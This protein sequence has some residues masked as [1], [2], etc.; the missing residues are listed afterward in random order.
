MI[1]L[2]GDL[3]PIKGKYYDLIQKDWITG[4]VT[5]INEVLFMFMNEITLNLCSTPFLQIEIEKGEIWLCITND[6]DISNLNTLLNNPLIQIGN[7][8]S[9]FSCENQNIEQ[10]KLDSRGIIT[11][12]IRNCKIESFHIDLSQKDR[13]HS[14]ILHYLKEFDL[15]QVKEFRKVMIILNAIQLL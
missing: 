2:R 12:S 10:L 14:N 9:F 15:T 6:T 5:F 3:S 11:N 7:W 8:S 4:L 1:D 13:F